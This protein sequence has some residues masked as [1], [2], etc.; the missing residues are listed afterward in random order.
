MWLTL[1][2]SCTRS[3][4]T[5]WQVNMNTPIEYFR[6]TSEDSFHTFVF[7]RSITS[8]LAV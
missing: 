4:P 2:F 7:G 3:D 1:G 8:A 6:L 5:R